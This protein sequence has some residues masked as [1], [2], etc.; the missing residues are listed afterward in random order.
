MKIL[1]RHCHRSPQRSVGE[2]WK[3]AVRLEAVM[4]LIVLEA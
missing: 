4:A 3:I 1:D 2:P